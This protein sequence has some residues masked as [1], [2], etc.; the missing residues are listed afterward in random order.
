MSENFREK[1]IQ[2]YKEL[3]ARPCVDTEGTNTF[4]D[5]SRLTYLK[6]ALR[7]EDSLYHEIEGKK[8][9]RLYAQDDLESIASMYDQVILVSSHADNLQSSSSFCLDEE[10]GIVHGCGD[11]ASTLSVLLTIMQTI[12]L[13]KNVLFV[14]TAD[15]EKKGKGAKKAAK[16]LRKYF[17]NPGAI[18]VIVLDVTF[19]Y[20]N[21]ADFTLENDFVLTAGNGEDYISN[22]IHALRDGDYVW[23]YIAAADDEE[24]NGE[25]V[26][27]SEMR[28]MM[29]DHCNDMV[30]TDGE[31]DESCL[32][33]DKGCTAFSFCLPCSAKTCDAMHSDEGFDI[34]LRQLERYATALATILENAA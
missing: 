9:Y 7:K 2:N 11:N 27:V 30:E 34:S 15:E 24:D 20:H 28:S 5:S 31:D 8:K 6:E 3:E 1:I 16:K 29:G 23:D 25:F 4:G 19:G 17:P 10:R 18:K 12:P 32:Y 14:A 22:V 21:G 33:R 13:N 26:T